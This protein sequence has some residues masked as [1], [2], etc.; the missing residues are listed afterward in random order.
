MKLRRLSDPEEIEMRARDVTIGGVLSIA[1]AVAIV[2]YLLQSTESNHAAVLATVCG[3]WVLCAAGLFA[4]PARRLA[5]SRA[6]EP[7]FLLWSTT[8]VGSIAVGIVIEGRPGTPLTAAF[9]LP[10][11]FAAISYP[12]LGTAIVGSMVLAGTAGA[13]A[14]VG[15]TTADMTFWLMT[16][17][18]AGVMGVWQ[19]YGRERR[20]EQLKREHRRAQLYLDV[21]GTMIVVLDPTGAIE[22]I[23]RRSCEV[24]GYTEDELLGRNWFEMAVPDDIRALAVED[25]TQ[26]LA[27]IPLKHPVREKDVITRSGERRCVSWNGRIVRTAN[28]AGMLIAGE[29]VT[30]R[31]VAQERVRHMAYHDGLTGL[32]NRT[33]LEEH[34]TLALA[35]ARRHEREAAVLYIDLDRFKLVNDTLGHGAGDE[36]L[37]RSPNASAPAPARATCSPVTAATSSCCCSPTSKATHATTARQVA[38]ELLATLEQPFRI[39]GHEFE[40]GGQHRRAAFPA[41]GNET[42]D[43][44]AAQ[45][46]HRHVRGQARGPRPGHASPRRAA[47]RGRPARRSPHACAA[48]STATSS[49]CTTSPIVGDAGRRGR[50]VEALLRWNDPERGLVAPGDFIPVAEDSGPDR[51]DRRLGRRRRDRPGRRVARS[52]ADA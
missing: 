46:R 7:F 1:T 31:R 45:R 22:Q 9:I 18:F 28:G 38:E 10:L 39:E 52:R 17:A 30:E 33:K 37:G 5:A 21:A 26:T 23:N 25:F 11:I 42:S 44:A 51:A 24:L 40:I 48:H 35:R 16:L 43:V 14:L 50:R 41:D 20:T 6:R 27:G 8:V 15:Q 3:S 29:D 49:S 12:V 2:T 19:A 32:A 4:L 13:G 34:I 47:A 36:L